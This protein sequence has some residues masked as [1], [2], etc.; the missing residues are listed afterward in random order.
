MVNSDHKKVVTE[1]YSARGKGMLEFP[2]RTPGLWANESADGSAGEAL[3]RFSAAGGRH[4]L[5]V[6]SASSNT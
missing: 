3:K 4:I 6:S 2:L 5:A 1:S